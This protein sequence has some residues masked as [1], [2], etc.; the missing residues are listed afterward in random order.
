MYLS[1]TIHNRVDYTLSTLKYLVKLTTIQHTEPQSQPA[2]ACD[3]SWPQLYTIWGFK[4]NWTTIN[5]SHEDQ[6]WLIIP[7][8]VGCRCRNI[9]YLA[10]IYNI[11]APG[12][13]FFITHGYI[14]L[15]KNQISGMQFTEKSMTYGNVPSQF[16]KWIHNMHV[17]TLMIYEFRTPRRF[18]A[19]HLF[20]LGAEWPYNSRIVYI[21]SNADR[22]C[23]WLHVY[24]KT[25]NI[26]HTLVGHKIFDHSRCSWS[27]ACR[28]CS[29]YIFILD[30]TP[31][32]STILF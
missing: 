3:C 8:Y 16:R 6:H 7:N 28:L 23:Y 14:R 1:P 19:L 4:Y 22:P 11:F 10:Y 26:S 2:G 27:I 13:C 24:R 29:N 30:S 31:R 32:F 9:S 12:P 21:H 18:P 25:S 5:Q 20:V 15:D 17:S